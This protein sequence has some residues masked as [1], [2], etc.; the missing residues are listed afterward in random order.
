MDASGLSASASQASSLENLFPRASL[1]TTYH[2]DAIYFEHRNFIRRLR[3][4]GVYTSFSHHPRCALS[5]MLREL[6]TRAVS[7]RRTNDVV[8]R[9]PRSLRTSFQ[10][11]P[12]N[13]LPHIL[14][15]NCNTGTVT[16]PICTPSF[17]QPT[18]CSISAP[19]ILQITNVRSCLN[20]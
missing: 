18:H 19:S 8:S 17:V 9:C 5:V 1:A 11:D 3:C 2:R 13:E 16:S 14:R 12:R 10:A 15:T 20:R 6:G 4:F 7:R